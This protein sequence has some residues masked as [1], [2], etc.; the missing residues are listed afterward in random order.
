MRSRE[1]PFSYLSAFKSGAP[2]V[3]NWSK[4]SVVSNDPLG[5]IV[6]R[7]RP[8]QEMRLGLGVG[9]SEEGSVESFKTSQAALFHIG[10][11]EVDPRKGFLRPK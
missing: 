8:G 10:S 3:S 7:A 6:P 1:T 9:Y 2:A 4:I 11:E 5:A